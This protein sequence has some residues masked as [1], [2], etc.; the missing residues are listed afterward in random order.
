MNDIWPPDYH[1]RI[2]QKAKRINL[3][4]CP[5]KGLEI[6][7]PSNGTEKAALAFLNSKRAWFLKHAHILNK[8]SSTKILPQQIILKALDQTWQIRYEKVANS[9]QV[10][11]IKLPQELA[12]YGPIDNYDL[13]ITKIKLWLQVQSEKYLYLWLNKISQHMQLPFNNLSV[14]NQKTRWGSC[15]N[16]KNINLN[17]KLLFLPYTLVEYVMI[18]E[19]CHTIHMN[20]SEKFWQLVANYYP[21]YLEAR[22]EIIRES[23]LIPDW[24]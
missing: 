23:K 19:L 24:V 12:V 15:N 21:N 9:R 17:Y 2:S 1:L 3:R 22:S 11:L 6:V 7:I 14:R 8:I 5:K 13:C 20:H 4:L 18:H 16:K 10:K